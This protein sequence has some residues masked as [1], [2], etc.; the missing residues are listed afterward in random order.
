MVAQEFVSMK[1]LYDIVPNLLPKPIAYGTYAANPNIHFFVSEF[2]E[3]TDD[4]PDISFMASLADLHSKTQSPDNKYGF[5]IP[6]FQRTVPQ[7]TEWTDSWEEFFSNSIKHIFD[8]EEKTHG[9]DKEL[10]VLE[11]AIIQKVIPRLLRPLETGGRSIQPCLIHGDVWD[12]NTSTR[13]ADNSPVL[14]DAICI[15][16]HNE[17]MSTSWNSNRH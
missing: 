5:S 8:L 11:R 2:V 10:K 4:V 9:V 14:F 17:G 16:A 1:T 6:T 7:H 12:G 15:Y 13:V 3:M